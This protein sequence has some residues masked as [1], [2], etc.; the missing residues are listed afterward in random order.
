MTEPDVLNIPWEDEGEFLQIYIDEQ[1]NTVL[2]L[3]DYPD[4]VTIYPDEWDTISN[5]VE[6]QRNLRLS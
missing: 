3:P 4:A 6:D 5:F 2:E 1:G